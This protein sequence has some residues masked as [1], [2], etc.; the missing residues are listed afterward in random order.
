[1]SQC[2]TSASICLLTHSSNPAS[3]ALANQIAHARKHPP[4]M[5]FLS[6]CLCLLSRSWLQVLLPLHSAGECLTSLYERGRGVVRPHSRRCQWCCSLTTRSHQLSLTNGQDE[7]S[8][9]CCQHSLTTQQAHHDMQHA[10]TQQL[11]ASALSRS[12]RRCQHQQV[13]WAS[14][15][16]VRCC[17]LL[18]CAGDVVNR[19]D[20]TAGVIGAVDCLDSLYG[21]L[22]H[23]N[24][25]RAGCHTRHLGAADNSGARGRARRRRHAP[26][27][28]TVCCNHTLRHHVTVP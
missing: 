16:A 7:I 21:R 1:M 2:H 14:R 4:Y 22:R 17:A 25:R 18:P 6:S 11:E 20:S 13:D 24:N 12:C 27:D 28:A 3:A 26:D 5:A 8:V 10:R 9:R 19:C 15:C 23:A